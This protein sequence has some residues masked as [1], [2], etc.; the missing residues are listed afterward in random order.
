MGKKK[1]FASHNSQ[2]IYVRSVQC[3]ISRRIA[4]ADGGRYCKADNIFDGTTIIY[5]ENNNNNDHNGKPA[6]RP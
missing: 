5:F 1:V 6:F 2:R 3:F 4:N